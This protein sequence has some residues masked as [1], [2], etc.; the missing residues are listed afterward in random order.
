MEFT[1]ADSGRTMEIIKSMDFDG[2]SFSYEERAEGVN[3]NLKYD[4]KQCTGCGI[5][6]K[7]C[8]TSALELGPIPEIATGL[9]AP[10]VM[11]DLDKCAFCGMCASFCPEKAFKLEIDGRD[12]RDLGEYPH[13]DSHIRVNERCIPCLICEKAC[14][15]DAIT[16]ELSIP[17]KDDLLIF[18]ET[19]RGEIR[20][21]ADKC[22]RCGI[23]SKICDAFVLMERESEAITPENPDEFE[24]VMIDPEKCDYCGLCADICPE[25]A[26]EVVCHE[27]N[28]KVEVE[29]PQIEG[30]IVI[31]D[32]RCNRCGWCVFRCPYDAIE[33]E[34]PFDGDIKIVDRK[35]PD[36][37]PVGCHACINI[38][39]SRAWYIPETEKI[40]VEE[41]LCTY[42][43]ACVN[44]CRFDVIDLL[45][46][47]VKHTPVIE[48]PWKNQWLDTIAI[49]KGEKE[50]RAYE[51]LKFFRKDEE[52][53]VVWR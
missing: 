6:V 39:P 2:T 51:G 50:R 11:L 22:N 49:I 12:I 46:R 37:D 20:I 34:K 14:P 13:L 21:D 42:C 23:C 19:A 35:L 41:S 9:D 27:R 28:V 24:A 32:D 10:P 29:P 16:L 3:R 40:A 8:P 18:D 33:I 7:I 52:G 36:C 4:Y 15:K 25:G 17:K 48:T 53:K 30:G 31:D 45:R 47:D 38:C 1:L 5:C 26:I 44:S 43:G